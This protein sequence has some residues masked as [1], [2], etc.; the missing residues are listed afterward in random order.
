M[1]KFNTIGPSKLTEWK[2]SGKD[3]QYK[4]G[5]KAEKKSDF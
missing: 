2:M 4:N 5:T 3:G 1:Q